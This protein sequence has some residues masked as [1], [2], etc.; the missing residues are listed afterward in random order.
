MAK[1]G[2]RREA[3]GEQLDRAFQVLELRKGGGSF[4]QIGAKIGMSHT[5]ARKDFLLAI[6][7]TKRLLGKK[8]EA[9]RA[10]EYE[11]LEMP[12]LGLVE[13]VRAGDDAA[14]TTWIRLSESRRRLLGLDAPTRLE[15]AGQHGG[16][17]RI[18]RETDFKRLTDAELDDLER[19][20]AK[21]HP[22]ELDG[23]PKGEV[24]TP[25]A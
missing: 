11:R 10:L 19:I 22:A 21:L 1:R 5:Q 4:R 9:L 24:D 18:R 12:V 6:D 8:A 7:S 20:A 3:Q 16:P 17:I 14:I 13:R 2:R 23:D 25:S 15:H